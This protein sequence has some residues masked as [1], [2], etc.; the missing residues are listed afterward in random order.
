[1]RSSLL[2]LTFTLIACGGTRQDCVP[3]L[4]W[5]TDLG[6]YTVRD[7]PYWRC[8]A[9]WCDQS[10]SHPDPTTDIPRVA[11]SLDKMIS[12]AHAAG[13]LAWINYSEPEVRWLV[14]GAIPRHS[15][16]DIISFD[17]YAGPH[18]WPGTESVAEH[19]RSTLVP[20]QRMALVVEHDAEVI[21][22]AGA[23]ACTHPE[24]EYVVRWP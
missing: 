8:D 11:A 7:E 4:D 24:V 13:R 10:A 19:L 23:Y 14:S 12:D 16:A 18:G 1:M 6:D 20:G 9:L 15:R 17:R 2:T 21:R 22:Q 5:R 3:V